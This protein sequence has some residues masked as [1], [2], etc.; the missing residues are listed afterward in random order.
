[1]TGREERHSVYNV[2]NQEWRTHQG[3]MLLCQAQ[4]L[5]LRG[6]NEYLMPLPPLICTCSRLLV[7]MVSVTIFSRMAQGRPRPAFGLS[8]DV[9]RHGGDERESV[10]EPP[11][12][13]TP[14]KGVL[15]V[16]WEGQSDQSTLNVSGEGQAPVAGM[17]RD[18]SSFPAHETV[19]GGGACCPRE[20][21]GAAIGTGRPSP[22]LASGAQTGACPAQRTLSNVCRQ[23]LVVTTGGMGCYWQ[24][25]GRTQGRC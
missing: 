3:Q 19:W 8:D 17:L 18:S 14:G 6:G 24:L 12:A 7:K 11:L 20:G 10:G 2:P 15:A 9:E 21:K 1:M 22:T 25:V 5:G 13:G 16:P 23:L 4:P